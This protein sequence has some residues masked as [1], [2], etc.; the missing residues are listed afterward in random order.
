MRI[1]SH[2]ESMGSS[3]SRARTTPNTNVPRLII[4]CETVVQELTDGVNDGYFFVERNRRKAKSVVA[5][6][7]VKSDERW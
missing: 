4:C 2:S 6:S 7:S 5:C 1:Q 3:I